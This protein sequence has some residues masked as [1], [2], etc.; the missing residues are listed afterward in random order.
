[1][2]KLIVLV[3]VVSLLTG[4]NEQQVESEYD[5]LVKIA[6]RQAVEIAIIEQAIRLN[7]L[8]AMM[9]EKANDEHENPD[10]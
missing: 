3:I 5:T 9:A 7:Q 4:C 10:S 8:K 1:M 2:K 6:D